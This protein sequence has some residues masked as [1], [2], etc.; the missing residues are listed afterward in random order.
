MWQFAR[1]GGGGGVGGGLG[2]QFHGQDAIPRRNLH[3]NSPR[4][5]CV[6][7]SS[8]SDDVEKIQIPPGNRNTIFEFSTLT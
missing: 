7:L 5:A 1:G 2:D 8:G 6:A 4:A 3:R